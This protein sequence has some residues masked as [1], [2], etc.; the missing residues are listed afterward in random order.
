MT[1]FETAMEE[2]KDPRVAC[3]LHDALSSLGE[4][5]NPTARLVNFGGQGLIF[6]LRSERFDSPLLIKIPFY[7]RHPSAEIAE[8]G[9]LK[10]AR[11]AEAITGSGLDLSPRLIAYDGG[12]RYLIREFASGEELSQVLDRSA[13]AERDA[14]LVREY[15][16]VRKLFPL[17]HEN[18]R[19]PYTIRDLKPKNIICTSECKLYIIDC[20]SCRPE[21]QMVS[22]DREKALRRFGSGKYLHWPIEQLTEDAAV[23]DRRVDYFAW[24]V[25]AYYTLFLERPYA[26]DLPDVER[27][28]KAYAERY[29][30]ARERLEDACRQGRLSAGLKDNIAA[31]LQPDPRKR[32][33]PEN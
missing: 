5:N 24:G 10:E 19:E 6:K 25:M 12:G 30:A 9:I 2:A 15:D 3:S 18:R 13:E 11:I 14:L 27:A 8:H 23:L 29:A 1:L 31:S 22:K 20:G 32:S 4:E 7:S 26:N 33:F 17:F 28:K 16:L 21:A